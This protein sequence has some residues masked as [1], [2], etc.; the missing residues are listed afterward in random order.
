MSKTVMIVVS[1]LVAGAMC[2]IG[3]IVISTFHCQRK[4]RE[5]IRQYYRRRY[6]GIRSTATTPASPIV[7][8][9]STS[10]EST[11]FLFPKQENTDWNNIPVKSNRVREAKNANATSV[12]QKN[13]NEYHEEPEVFELTPIKRHEAT[14]RPDSPP[15]KEK[16]SP[17]VTFASSYKVSDGNG[18]VM[19]VKVPSPPPLPPKTKIL[20][21]AELTFESK[22][23]VV[24][25][26]EKEEEEEESVAVA[27]PLPPK[28]TVL[29][30]N[31]AEEK[32]SVDQKQ[33]EEHKTKGDE[34]KEEK[35][36]VGVEV[37]VE[38]EVEEDGQKDEEREEKEEQLVQKVESVS[39]TLV[40]SAVENGANE[41]VE[42]Q[43][44]GTTHEGHGIETEKDEKNDIAD[45]EE[46]E[47]D[48]EQEEEEEERESDKSE[49]APFGCVVYEK[50][51]SEDHSVSSADLCNEGS[52]LNEASTAILPMSD[53]P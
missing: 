29:L 44:N 21:Y 46:E 20:Y 36:K 12:G 14:A 38:V 53:S 5:R 7:V 34:N 40:V 49:E 1:V 23:N 22:A 16:R 10:S 28:P 42:L 31:K 26:E 41:A 2:I 43:K 11:G 33:E 52:S 13:V 47:E 35:A 50:L 17:V 15:V 32:E 37:E 3:V 18:H 4:K 8:P 48:E 27:P 51:V 39:S 25:K 6:R 19:Q 24:V 9:M 30:P 45:Q